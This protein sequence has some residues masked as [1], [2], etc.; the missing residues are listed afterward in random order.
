MHKWVRVE[1]QQEIIF[2]PQKAFKFQRNVEEILNNNR[3]LPTKCL[4]WDLSESKETTEP[5]ISKGRLPMMQLHL[6]LR[7]HA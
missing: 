4:F 1:N 7:K 3:A 5:E 2:P 6:D